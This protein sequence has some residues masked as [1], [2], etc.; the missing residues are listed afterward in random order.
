MATIL[1]IDGNVRSAGL[2]GCTVC[3]QAIQIARR[4]AAQAD[5]DV[6]LYDDDGV[7]RV[8]PDGSAEEQSDKQLEALGL[9]ETA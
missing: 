8:R 1:D 9:M 2:Q 6:L 3:D 5:E 4:Q 7:W